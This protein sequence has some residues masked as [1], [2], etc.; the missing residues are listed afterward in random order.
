MIV[1]KLAKQLIPKRKVGAIC[2]LTPAKT[3]NQTELQRFCEIKGTGKKQKGGEK[4]LITRPLRFSACNLSFLCRKEAWE[5]D[6][7]T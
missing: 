3:H 7:V 1:D 4:L 5:L 2:L 6:E